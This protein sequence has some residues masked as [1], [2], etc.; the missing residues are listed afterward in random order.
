VLIFSLAGTSFSDAINSEAVAE[1]IVA[2][3]VGSI[4][5][6]AA[7]PITTALAAL[8]VTR[9]QPSALADAHA[10]TRTEQ[11][12]QCPVR[13]A[14]NVRRKT[15]AKR[16]TRTPGGLFLG[17]APRQEG[18]AENRGSS[19]IVTV[20]DRPQGY[21]LVS[22]ESGRQQRSQERTPLAALFPRGQAQRQFS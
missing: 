6:I 20:R 13:T 14:P 22:E 12:P 19:S 1:Q 8:L 16:E 4:G 9:V 21:D 7:V 17:L 18:L 5:L 15:A 2:T 10:G 11:T 3:L